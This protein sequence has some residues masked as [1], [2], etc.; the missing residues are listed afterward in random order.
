M[1]IVIE[2][3]VE[4]LMK[5]INCYRNNIELS[6]YI[7]KKLKQKELERKI[8]NISQKDNIKQEFRNEILNKLKEKQ[9]KYRFINRRVFSNSPPFNTQPNK[10]NNNYSRKEKEHNIYSTFEDIQILHK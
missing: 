3:S 9:N 2:K 10:T 5:K 7:K 4:A 8:K 6:K 1:L